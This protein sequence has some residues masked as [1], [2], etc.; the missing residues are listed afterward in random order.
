M[1]PEPR[2]LAIMT[3]GAEARIRTPGTRRTRLTGAARLTWWR[4]A[5]P[6]CSTA[7]PSS[8]HLGTYPDSKSGYVPFPGAGECHDHQNARTACNIG[9]QPFRP[10]VY[11]VKAPLYGAWLTLISSALS[12]I[13]SVG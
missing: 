10:A 11:G 8:C 9:T 2:M 13:R 7:S 12:H 1:P 5:A 3:G 6:A 4:L